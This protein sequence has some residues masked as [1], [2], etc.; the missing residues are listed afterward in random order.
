[1]LINSGFTKLQATAELP[2]TPWAEM[3]KKRIEWTHRR[4]FGGAELKTWKRDD[5]QP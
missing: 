1:M 3:G 4:L 2:K 5:G